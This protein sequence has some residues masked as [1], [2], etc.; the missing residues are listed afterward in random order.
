MT[1]LLLAMAVVLFGGMPAA[2]AQDPGAQTPST[3]PP[4]SAPA[5]QQPRVRVFLDCF[6]C[7]Q[8]FLRDEI[9]WVDFVRQAQDA[10]VHVLSSSRETGGGGREVVLRFVGR[11]RFEGHDHDLRALTQPSD[12]ENVRREVILRT[13]IV[14]LLDY[15]AHDGIPGGMSL[16]VESQGRPAQQA[17]TRDP[18]NLWVFSLEGDMSANLEETNRERNWEIGFSADRVTPNWKISFGGQRSE[19]VERFN[20]GEEDEFEATRRESDLEAFIAKSLGP[21]WSVG[22]DAEVRTSTFG[23]TELSVRAAPAIEFSVFPYEEYATR[24][25]RITYTAGFERARYN[26]V[27]IFDKLEEN[28]WR[29][30]L[31]AVLD[32]RQ[33]WGTLR[34]RS[35]VSQYLHDRGL[36]RLEVGGFLSWRIVRGLSMNFDFGASRIRDQLSL[37]RRGA[38]PEEVL[39]RLRQLQSGYEVELFYGLRYTFGSLFNNVVNPRFGN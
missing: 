24:Q 31:S 19:Q 32:Q 17:E 8:E 22:A 7:F 13:A 28:L 33:P 1:R 26:E 12:T 21:H 27:T 5:S 20:V 18:W 2:A 25:F 9:E 4:S 30:Q 39:L 3:P 16:T 6:D 10:E 11:G 38:T 37:P 35:E 29:Q 36:Y 14:G 23:N 34:I 15:V